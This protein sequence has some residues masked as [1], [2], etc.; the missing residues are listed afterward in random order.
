MEKREKI[1]SC[2]Y[3]CIG[4]LL[5]KR[6]F[7][8]IYALTLGLIV[9]VEFAA[10]ISTLV[11][12]NKL[13]K[14]YDSGFMELFENSYRQ[15]LTDAIKTIQ[16]LEKEFECCGV[17]DFTD[18]TKHG[19]KIPLSCYSNPHVPILPY[20]DGC[21]Y[22]VANWLWDKLPIIASVLGAVLFIELFGLASSLILGVAIS[23]SS[24]NEL[25]QK[26]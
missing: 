21:A 17:D 19:W 13:W 2:I 16:T 4:A 20:T 26:F 8:Y 10:V 1:V 24:E 22:A 6:A 12:R 23:H 25:Y 3:L 15:N 18:Y 11:Y 5:H 9:I 7:L 14:T